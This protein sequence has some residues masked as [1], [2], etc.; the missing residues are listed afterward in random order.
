LSTSAGA[1]S[2]ARRFNA[3]DGPVLAKTVVHAGRSVALSGLA[4]S[5][6]M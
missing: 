4:S 3:M 2:N 5:I 6:V 1:D